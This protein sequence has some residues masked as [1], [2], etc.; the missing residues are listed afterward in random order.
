MTSSDNFS[1]YQWV[2]G[3]K[4]VCFCVHVYEDDQSMYVCSPKDGLI[5]PFQD[6]HLGFLDT[7]FHWDLKLAKQARLASW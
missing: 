1:I 6:V 5:W 3:H 4:K 2:G 7:V